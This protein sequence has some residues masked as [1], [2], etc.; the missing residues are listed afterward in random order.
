M[1]YFFNIFKNNTVSFDVS[2]YGIS[3]VSGYIPYFTA[4]VKN[5][6]SSA[7]IE[8]IGWIKDPSGAARFFIPSSDT[9]INATGFSWDVTIEKDSSIF[10]IDF[11]EGNIS[12]KSRY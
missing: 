12:K 11:G 3:D 5:S 2:I 4:K 9:S 7:L 8:N 10:T 6:D 1:S